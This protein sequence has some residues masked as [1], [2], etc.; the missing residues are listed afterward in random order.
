[1]GSGG[2]LCS[3]GTKQ[4]GGSVTHQALLYSS[5]EEFLAATVPLIQ[6]GLVHGDPIRI[7]TTDRN[8]DWLRSALGTDAKRVEFCP[9]SECYRHPARALASTH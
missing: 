4:V 6:D 2:V 5:E 1:M 9:S 8:S 3:L 7:A